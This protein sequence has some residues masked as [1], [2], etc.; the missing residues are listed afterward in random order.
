VEEAI[1]VERAAKRTKPNINVSINWVNS[2]QDPKKA[3]SIAKTQINNGVDVLVSDADLGNF[4]VLQAAN[5]NQSVSVIT[6]IYPIDGVQKHYQLAG[7]NIVTFVIQK[8][9]KLLLEGATLAQQGRWEGKQY[10][11]GILEGVQDLALFNTSL[12]PQEVK[13]VKSLKQDIITGKIDIAP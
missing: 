5:T 13:F 9:P 7:S 3:K 8:I 1:L 11:L 2:W 6:W 12:T 10:K 4:G